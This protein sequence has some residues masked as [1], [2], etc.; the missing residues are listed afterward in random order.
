MPDYSQGKI[1][2]IVS[3]NHSKI[4]IGSTVKTLARRFTQ[5]KSDRNCCSTEIIDAGD[6]DIKLIEL[7]PCLDK[8]QLE[9][10]EAEY[11]LMD[12]DGCV[13][14]RVAGA[15][16][17]AGGQKAYDKAY[18]KANAET[19]KAY[20]EAYY[21][22]NADKLKENMKAYYEEN[23]DKLKENMKAYRE[24]NADKIKA[25]RE[26]NRESINAKK[27]QKYTCFCGGK[28]THGSKSTHRKT[29]RH[30]NFVEVIS[31]V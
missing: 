28:Y 13:N 3:P 12:W 25:H 16:R 6:S 2:Q 19:I 1:Y 17:R 24:A 18:Q 5:H 30:Q 22:A 14:D 29:K 27:R 9:D 15:W 11:Q 4:Y 10:R 20:R 23:A 21:E 8:A 7:F 31:M 26:A